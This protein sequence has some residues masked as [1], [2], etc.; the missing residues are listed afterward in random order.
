[1]QERV[2]CTFL[3]TTESHVSVQQV[4]LSRITGGKLHNKITYRPEETSLPHSCL[5]L[6]A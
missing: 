2:P 4:N 5:P 6:L 1:M 3:V